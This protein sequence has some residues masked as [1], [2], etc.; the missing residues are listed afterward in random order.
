MTLCDDESHVAAFMFTILTL[1]S[2]KRDLLTLPLLKTIEH[3]MT[4]SSMLDQVTVGRALF[5][6]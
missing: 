3:F 2:E 6:S 5:H 4:S 1:L